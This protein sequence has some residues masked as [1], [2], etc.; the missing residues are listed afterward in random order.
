MEEK[1]FKKTH[2]DDD[3][4][5]KRIVGKDIKG[6]KKVLVGLTKI[7]GVNWSY[8]NA[9]CK[10]LNIDP[11]KRINDLTAEEVEKIDNFMKNPEMPSYLMNR[12]KDFSTGEDYHYYGA[13]LNLR[14]EF[15]IKRLK[16]I[17]SYKG[18]RHTAK[19]PVRGQRTKSNF[20]PNK[21]KS[22]V[23]VKKKS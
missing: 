10:I 17:K 1:K 11:N 8:S 2:E 19:L 15:D 14:N 7:K 21:G 22:G 20:R 13:D 18:I 9:I 23:G 16:K 6:N 3:Y 12:Q 4:Q 5:V